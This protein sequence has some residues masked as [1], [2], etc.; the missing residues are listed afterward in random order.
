M[1][2]DF[3][4]ELTG[5]FQSDYE[6]VQGEDL[7][8][9]FADLGI[10]KKILKG[11]VVVNFAVKDVFESRVYESIILNTNNYNNNT[12]MRGRFFTL[13]FSYGFGRGE[14]MT[15]SGSRR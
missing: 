8:F 2:A 3:D 5:Q 15:Y 14:A 9:A 10:R 6:T 4:L 12:S 13:G 1:P 7:G 11:K